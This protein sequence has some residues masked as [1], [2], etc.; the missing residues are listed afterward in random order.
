MKDT[1]FK[2]SI[3][4]DSPIPYKLEKVLQELKRL[5]EGM[6]PG[7]AGKEKQGPFF[8]KVDKIYSTT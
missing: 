6:V 5:D 1:I 3:T 8:W 2:D 4:I 7:A